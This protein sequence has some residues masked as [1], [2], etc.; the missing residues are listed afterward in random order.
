MTADNE[1]MSTAAEP[2]RSDLEAICKA[3]AAGRKVDPD[4]AKRVREK[5]DAIR[6]SA[7]DNLS[8]ETLRSIREE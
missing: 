4:I 2:S 1:G 6:K 3:V 7:S 5:S 8:V